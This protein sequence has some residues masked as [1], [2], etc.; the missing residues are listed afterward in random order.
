M[1]SKNKEKEGENQAFLAIGIAFMA[2]GVSFMTGENTGVGVAFLV[3]GVAFL[4]I[5]FSKNIK[6]Q[7]R[8]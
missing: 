5:N 8:K 7:R 3:L 4:S 2:I 6:D 1:A